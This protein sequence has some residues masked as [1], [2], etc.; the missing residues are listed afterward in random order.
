MSLPS[1]TGLDHYIIRVNDLNAATAQYRKLGF[2]LAPQGVHHQGTRNQTL[3]LDANY[4]ELLY[5]P[6]CK[7]PRA[8]RITLSHTKGRWRWRCRPPTVRRCTVSWHRSASTPKHPK[9]AAGRCICRMVPRT[10][11]G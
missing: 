11:P 5:F 8:S 6:R 7:P 9:A 4:L 10:Q 3:I 1:V 2:A